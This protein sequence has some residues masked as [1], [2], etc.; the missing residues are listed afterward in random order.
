MRER[1]RLEDMVRLLSTNPAKIFGLWG[2]K[3]DLASGFDGDLVI[4]DP[5]PQRVLSQ[6]ELHSRAG[7]SPYEG[8]KLTGRV[9]TTIRRGEVVYD[10]GKILGSAGSGEF[11]EC[12]PFDPT[13]KLG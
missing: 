2:I 4:F 8:L 6:S 10:A 7:F 11:L 13:I 9:R 5:K 1:I 3:G 12:E